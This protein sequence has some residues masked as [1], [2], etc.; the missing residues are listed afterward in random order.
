[1]EVLFHERLNLL[2][3]LSAASSSEFAGSINESKSQISK[4]LHDKGK[5][6]YETL[7]SILQ[8]FPDLNGRWLLLGEKPVFLRDF[9]TNKATDD[10]IKASHQKL[11]SMIEGL[12]SHHEEAEKELTE[13]IIKHRQTE[14]ELAILKKAFHQYKQMFVEST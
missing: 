7:V 1:M 4:Y 9:T 3:Q 13:L 2:I 12:M 5:P 10:L 11:I 8:K 6:G 14:K